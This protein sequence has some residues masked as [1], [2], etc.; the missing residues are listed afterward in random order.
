MSLNRSSVTKKLTKW[1]QSPAIRGV[2][3]MSLFRYGTKVLAYGRLI[4]LARFFGQQGPYE[5]GTFSLAILVLAITEV[6]TQTGINIVLIKDRRLLEQYLDT[7][8]IISV[9]RG[10]LIALIIWLLTPSIVSFFGNPQLAQY[11]SWALV[12]PVVRGLLNPAIITYQ[13]NLEFGKE[14]L[15]R[16]SVQLLDMTAGLFIALYLNSALGLLLG[17]L[18]GVVFELVMSFVLFRPWPSLLGFKWPLIPSLFAKTRFVI[19]NGIMTYLNEN[20]DDLL[21]GRIL[22]TAT[23]GLYTMAYK[24]ASAVTIEVGNILRDTL[25]PLYAR[26][27]KRP[28]ELKG[29]LAKTQLRQGLFYGAVMIGALVL[30]KPVVLLTMGAEWLPMVPALQILVASGSLRGFYNSWYPVFLLSDTVARSFVVN[31]MSTLTMVVSILYLAPRYG[32]VGASIAILLSVTLTLPLMWWWR[33]K[34]IKVLV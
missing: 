13:Q 11:L 30:S 24:L 7:A 22:G 5:M 4:I 18:I 19:F 27:L 20:L 32:L 33:A 26:L 21:I 6:F 15:F 17:M 12:V 2:S 16:T 14:S 10:L 34:A 31:T 8:W 25:Y 29:M 9:T 28:V 1:W 23:L 3:Y